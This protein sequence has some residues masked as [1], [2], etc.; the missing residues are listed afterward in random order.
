MSSEIILKTNYNKPNQLH[1]TN[2]T[3]IPR[4]AQNPITSTPNATAIKKVSNFNLTQCIYFNA[5][6]I[7]NKT[8]DLDILLKTD[9]F[10][11]V[12]IVE[13]WL[14]PVHTDSFVLNSNHYS[15]LRHDRISQGGGGVCICYN[16]T[17]ASKVKQLE[18]DPNL[19]CNFEIV[20]FDFYYSK[21]KFSR[22]VCVYISPQNSKNI[23]VVQNLLL[24]LRKLTLMSHFYVMGDF[25]FS[26][27][28]WSNPALSVNPVYCEFINYLNS[29]NLS[30]LILSPTHKHG[31][32]L[33][34]F[35]TSDPH[36]VIS[37]QIREPFNITCDHNMVEF[38]LNIK[39]P[40]R[41]V[42]LKQ[43]N[44]YHG[45]Y[46]KINNFLL[47]S[48]W[49]SIFS[50]NS[51]IDQIYLE[52]TNIIHTSIENFVPLYKSHKSSLPNH[53]KV[54]INIKKQLYKI[55]RTDINV[56]TLYKDFDK[57][58]KAT[59]SK[60]F[61]NQERKITM[62]ASKKSFFSYINRKLKS[63]S[64]LSPLINKNN[65]IITDPVDKA[66]LLNQHFESVFVKDNNIKPKLD[67]LQSLPDLPP[68]ES[69]QI[70]TT[71][72][73][74]AISKLKSS[75]AQTPDQIPSLFI[76]RTSS[77]L[78]KPFTLL[79]NLSLNLGRVPKKWKQANVIPVP[80]NKGVKTDPAN[81]R[82]ISLTPAPCRIL[83]SIVHDHLVDYL[84]PNHLISPSQHGFVRNR[85]TLTQ[86]IHF[87]TN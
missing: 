8:P 29:H 7:K 5:G 11:F 40:K 84:I 55:T 61:I 20:A 75:V 82:P 6:S 46:E 51:D 87:L 36:N 65:E 1:I 54:L 33:D 57:M 56:K 4:S 77:S 68:M 41:S 30:Q 9:N 63:R 23:V 86:Q 71:K 76:K 12:F 3:T 18:L 58:Y 80:K 25:N 34:L 21:F 27:I 60:Y 62:S 2:H 19:T 32:T 10:I 38:K 74:S 35:I 48:D 72:V 78:S 45:N 16:T 17:I 83:E 47:N 67:H 44:F 73:N 79:F 26:K 31:N 66:E 53:I 28:N 59:I 69:L 81:I 37:L 42:P 70:T 52:F 24:V 49:N 50:D 13:S 85:S 15:L 14:K 22:F 64:H 39:P 43:R